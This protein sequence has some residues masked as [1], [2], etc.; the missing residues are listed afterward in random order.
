MNEFE[1][2]LLDVLRLLGVRGTHYARTTIRLIAVSSTLFW[3]LGMLLPRL[4]QTGTPALVCAAI[5]GIIWFIAIGRVTLAAW[6]AQMV[7]EQWLQKLGLSVEQFQP[8]KAMYVLA[9]AGM[10]YIASLILLGIFPLW[11]SGGYYAVYALFWA[12]M[13]AVWFIVAT[14]EGDIRF[15]RKVYGWSIATVAAGMFALLLLPEEV[16][17]FRSWLERRALYTAAETAFNDRVAFDTRRMIAKVDGD[18]RILVDERRQHQYTGLRWPADKE[19]ELNRLA[20]L[21]QNL[22]READIP[23]AKAP[24]RLSAETTGA[25]GG[26]NLP[27]MDP[28]TL[29]FAF[30]ALFVVAAAFKK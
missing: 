19:A 23:V 7:P 20:N 14:S 8:G 13:V 10:W 2:M 22:V 30:F 6:I 17:G 16:N 9:T 27:G 3:L 28:L 29:G 24:G 26:I 5:C 12:V 15:W 21:H 18:L 25:I 1:R 11:K 4:M